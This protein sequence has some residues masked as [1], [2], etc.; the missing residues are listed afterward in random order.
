MS[1][2]LTQHIVKHSLAKSWELDYTWP[3]VL[4]HKE[5]ALWL[6]FEFVVPC[7]SVGNKIGSNI[8]GMETWKK[9]FAI[10]GQSRGCFYFLRKGREESS[11]YV[12]SI[13]QLILS[14]FFF[15][16]SLLSE[17]LSGDHTSVLLN[18]LCSCEFNFWS[19]IW[20][21]RYYKVPL[22]EISKGNVC[23]KRDSFYALFLF[24][25]SAIYI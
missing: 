6:S 15:P 11:N 8:Q 7:R 18:P 25:T 12:L 20:S 10:F 3:C 4:A 13:N 16:L 5:F 14:F 19:R 1:V 2:C 23:N 21:F 22:S 9:S 24:L 17:L